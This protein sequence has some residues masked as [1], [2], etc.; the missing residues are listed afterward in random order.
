MAGVFSAPT[1]RSALAPAPSPETAT[2]TIRADKPGPVINRDIFGQ[3]SEMLGNGVYGGIW[4]GKDSPIPNIRG[5]RSDVTAALRE[6][7]VP[8]VRWPGGCF[9]DKYDWRDGVG[10]AQTRIST[11][12]LWGNVVDP[13]SF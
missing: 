10:P 7:H 5:I 2:L 12:N 3:F 6:I 8:V 13:N 11:V 1:A 4:V 9:A